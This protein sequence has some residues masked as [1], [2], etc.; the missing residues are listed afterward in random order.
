[1]LKVKNFFL[2]QMVII[3]ICVSC[4][5]SCNMMLKIDI[6]ELKIAEKVEKIGKFHELRPTLEQ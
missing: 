2:A 1:M 3:S 6:Q 5:F 4:C